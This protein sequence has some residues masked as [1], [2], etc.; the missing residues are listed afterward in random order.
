MNDHPASV[1][2][3]F[4]RGWKAIVRAFTPTA[5]SRGSHGDGADTTLFGT[6][7]DPPRSRHASNAPKDDFWDPAG[8]STDFADPDMGADSR[9]R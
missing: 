6:M 8:E 3:A 2:A 7:A 5:V 9:R 4:A 1:A